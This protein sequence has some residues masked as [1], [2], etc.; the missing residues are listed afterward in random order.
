MTPPTHF[1]IV[2]CN[3]HESD[4]AFSFSLSSN[5]F[6]SVIVPDRRGGAP[7]SE[8]MIEMIASGN[9]TIIHMTPPYIAF[10]T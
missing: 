5:C 4:T 3:D 1:R 7:R 8:S 10:D 9:H 6:R 2:L